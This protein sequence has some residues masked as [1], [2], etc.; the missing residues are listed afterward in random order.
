MR[1]QPSGPTTRRALLS[2]IALAAGLPASA[3]IPTTNAEVIV[4]GAGVAGL[5]AAHELIRRGRSVA[6]L[7]AADRIGGRAFTESRS[8]GVPVDHGCSWLAG[9]SDLPLLDMAKRWG[10]TLYDHRNASEALFVGNKRADPA[11]R[12]AIDRAY[13]VIEM[14]LA[15]AGRS[16]LDVAAASLV[17]SDLPFAEIPTNWIGPLDW[18]VDFSQLSTMDYWNSEDFGAYYMVKEGYGTL[19]ARMGSGLPVHLNTPATAL[20]WSGEGVAVETPVGTLRAKACI[21]TVSPGVLQ[22]GAIAFRPRLPAWK[23]DA[24]AN[25]PMGC[26]SKIVLQ[27]DGQRFGLGSNNWL[28]YAVPGPQTKEACYFLTFPFGFDL[29]IGFV[30]G[31]FGKALS[32]AGSDAAVNFALDELTRIFG[33]DVRRHVVKGYLANW[34]DNPLT[35]GAYAAARPGHFSARAALKRPLGERVYFAGDSVAM[36]YVSLCGGAYLSG[37]SVAREVADSLP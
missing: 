13:S 14:A 5:S 27:V 37:V 3:R 16:G 23:Q 8:F 22:G 10:F 7:E 21:V 18:A 28:S 32:A 36:P 26:L 24:I 17:P 34:M 35:L 6:I 33:N 4:I 19:V 1:T 2:G 29:M 11:Q 31:S 20:D 12:R 9:P 15:E 25:V 30:G